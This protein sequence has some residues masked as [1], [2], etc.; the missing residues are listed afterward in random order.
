MEWRGQER[1]EDQPRGFVE[2]QQTAIAVSVKNSYHKM[3]KL[4]F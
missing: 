1:K 4:F 2:V 3:E